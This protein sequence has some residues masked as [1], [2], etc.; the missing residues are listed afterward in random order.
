MKKL[1]DLE[2]KKLLS[3]YHFLLDEEEWKVKILEENKIDF[4]NQIGSKNQINSSEKDFGSH[5]SKTKK[6]FEIN[7]ETRFKIKKAYYK[8]ANLTHPDKES[9]PELN[10]IYQKAA[11]FYEENNILEIYMIAS[12]L[13]ISIEIEDSEI[14]NFKKVIE[15]KRSFLKSLEGSWLWLW[16]NAS[17]QIEKENIVDSFLK[18]SNTNK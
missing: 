11:L 6:I 4:L 14:Q 16:L 10:E 15:E 3:E 2:I 13:N 1:K 8:I 7:D 18:Y 17:T 12:K 9:D 5:Q